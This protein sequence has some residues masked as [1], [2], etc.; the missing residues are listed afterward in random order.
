[1]VRD[2]SGILQRDLQQLKLFVP[3]LVIGALFLRLGRFLQVRGELKGTRLRA[4]ED[5][6]VFWKGLGVFMMTGLSVDAWWNYSLI[7]AAVVTLVFL[8]EIRIVMHWRRTATPPHDNRDEMGG[9]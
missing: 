7:T 9:G 8:A 2:V 5:P 3:G 4:T 1:M 6:A